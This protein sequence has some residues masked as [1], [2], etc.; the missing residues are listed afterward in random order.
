VHFLSKYYY[1]NEESLLQS[2][3]REK[4]NDES[5]RLRMNCE[6]KKDKE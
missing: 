3:Y 6:D 2:K 1:A 5:E 4:E